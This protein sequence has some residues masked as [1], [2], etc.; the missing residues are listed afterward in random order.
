MKKPREILLARHQSATPKLNDVRHA[1]VERL[2]NEATKKQSISFVP[3]FLGCLKNIWSE[4]VFPSRRIWAGL[5]AVWVL[6]FI[7]NLS[8][9]DHPQ[10]TMAKTR[11][12]GEMAVAFKQQQ[13]ILAE[14]I[15]PNNPPIAEHKKPYSPGP[16]SLRLVEITAV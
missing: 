12:S 15:G 11:S 9:Q 8:M 2:N 1:I 7:A 13:Q 4:L 3:L 16:S 10:T 5:A 14:L 6:I